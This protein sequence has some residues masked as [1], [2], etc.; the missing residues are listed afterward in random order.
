[1]VVGTDP[2][3]DVFAAGVLF[4]AWV[5]Y[6][7]NKRSKAVSDKLDNVVVPKLDEVHGM[8]NAQLT[9]AVER[10]DISEAENVELRAA[11]PEDHPYDQGD[12]PVTP[13]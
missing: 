3:Q 1:M 5:T 6:R 7:G 10:R 11:H 2:V 12:L 4:L 9:A 13:A 8:V